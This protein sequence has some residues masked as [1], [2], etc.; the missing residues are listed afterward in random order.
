MD[1]KTFDRTCRDSF[2]SSTIENLTFHRNLGYHEECKKRKESPVSITHSVCDIL[3]V[4]KALQDFL[5]VN[6]NLDNPTFSDLR[7][8]SPNLYEYV[9]GEII[10]FC[11]KYYFKI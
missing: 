5:R 4:E 11:N 2:L 3:V 8:K 7:R 1:A 9:K 6:P 10:I